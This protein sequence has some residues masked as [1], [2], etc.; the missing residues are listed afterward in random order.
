MF[1]KVTYNVLQL[2]A[3]AK[4]ITKHYRNY[5]YIKIIRIK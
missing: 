3:V 2:V 1:F 5:E 4:L